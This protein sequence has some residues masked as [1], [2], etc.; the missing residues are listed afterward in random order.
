MMAG[1]IATSAE[2]K[3]KLYEMNKLVGALLGPFEAWLALRGLK[4]LPLRM[5]RTRVARRD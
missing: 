3:K 2:N 1:V 4:T 5:R